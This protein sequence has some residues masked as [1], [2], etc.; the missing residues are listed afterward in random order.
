M[1]QVQ[2][3]PFKAPKT[4]VAIA[5]KKARELVEGYDDDNIE[6][7]NTDGEVIGNGDYEIKEGDRVLIRATQEGWEAAGYIIFSI[8]VGVASYYFASQLLGNI[9]DKP[10]ESYSLTGVSNAFNKYSPVPSVLGRHRVTPPLAAQPWIFQEGEDEYIRALYLFGYSPMSLSDFKIGD[11]SLDSFVDENGDPNYELEIYDGLD[12]RTPLTLY[13]NDVFQEN[14][15]VET[16][17]IKT[18]TSSATGIT[19][20][21]VYVTRTVA[22]SGSEV[23]ATIDFPQGLYGVKND[24]EYVHEEAYHQITFR[25]DGA[26]GAGYLDGGTYTLL[27]MEYVPNESDLNTKGDINTVG[28]KVP[29]K[30]GTDYFTSNKP[31]NGLVVKESGSFD[32]DLYVCRQTS[33][34]TFRWNPLTKVYKEFAANGITLRRTLVTPEVIAGGMFDDETWYDDPVINTYTLGPS[35]II[36]NSFKQGGN[37]GSEPFRATFGLKKLTKSVYSVGVRRNEP[38]DSRRE[39]RRFDK[40]VYLFLTSIDNETPPV[41]LGGISLVAISI[42]ASEQ[43]NGQIEGFSAIAQAYTPPWNYANWG[44]NLS[45]SYSQ[46]GGESDSDAYLKSIDSD[47]ST[48]DSWLEGIRTFVMNNPAGVDDIDN[49]SSITVDSDPSEFM[50]P[51]ANPA[52]MYRWA[53]QGRSAKIRAPDSKLDF[54]LSEGSGSLEE[55]R[56]YCNTPNVVG[57]DVGA[58]PSAKRNFECNAVV[59]Y[60]TTVY[61]LLS[62]ICSTANGRFI[63]NNGKYGVSLDKAKDFS[64]QLFTDDNAEITSKKEFLDQIDG[65]QVRFKDETDDNYEQNEFPVINPLKKTDLGND[66]ENI[67]LWGV[68]NPAQA[69][70]LARTKFKSR[71]VRSQTFDITTDIDGIVCQTGDR[72][73]IQNQK[74]LR[75]ITGA[76]IAEVSGDVITLDEPVVFDPG[77]NYGIVVRNADGTVHTAVSITNPGVTTAQ[78]T[79]VGHSGVVGDLVSVGQSGIE[80][81]ELMV[82]DIEYDNDLRARLTAIPYVESL[83]DNDNVIDET[84]PGINIPYPDNVRHDA[85]VITGVSLIDQRARD[86]RG[87][88][89][90]SIRLSIVSPFIKNALNPQ[91]EVYY[92]Y[93]KD[94]TTQKIPEIYAGRVPTSAGSFLLQNLELGEYTFRVR[95]VSNTGESDF[96]SYTYTLS[97]DPARV[98]DVGTVTGIELINR[99]NNAGDIEDD[100]VVH[101]FFGEDAKFRWRLNALNNSE[102]IGSETF[103][104]DSGAQD[105][106]FEDYQVVIAEKKTVNIN[107]PTPQTITTYIPRREEIVA[108]PAYTYTYEDNLEDG[109]GVAT[110]SF[111]IAV[112]ARGSENQESQ[113]AFLDVKNPAPEIPQNFTASVNFTE[114]SFG[115]TKPTDADI[116]AFE[117]YVSTISGFDPELQDPTYSGPYQ[118]PVTL[119]NLEADRT[120]Y[121]RAR[122]VDTFGEGEFTDQISFATQQPSGVDITP[123]TAPDNL[124]VTIGTQGKNYLQ[125]SFAELSW[126]AAFDDSGELF[127][128]VEHGLVS[129]TKPT[130]ATT[131]DTTYIIPYIDVDNDYKF[132]VRA[133]DYSGNTSAWTGYSTVSA[134][135]VYD[136]PPGA[137]ITLVG[138]GTEFSGRDAEFIIEQPEI[139]DQENFKGYVVTVKDGATVLRT[140]EVSNPFYS[141]TYEKNVNDGGPRRTF[142]VE[143][144]STTTDGQ[145]GATSSITV[146]NPAPVASNVTIEPRVGALV[147]RYDEPTDTDFKGTR[148]YLSETSPVTINDTNLKYNGPEY[149]PSFITG[150]NLN[151][152]YYVTVVPYD[153]FG[154]GTPTANLS[155]VTL[156]NEDITPPVA[157]SNLVLSQELT[158]DNLSATV[159]LEASWD[160]GSD[161]SGNF[162]YYVTFTSANDVRTLVTEDTSTSLMPAIIG[163][164]YTVTV[165]SLDYSGNESTSSISDTIAIVGSSTSPGATTNE[166]VTG[167]LNKVKLTWDNPTT[168]NF[169]QTKVYRGTTAGFTANAGSLIAE[170]RNTVYVDIDV[171]NGTDY[172][173]KL[174]PVSA[175]GTNGT[176][177]AAVGPA[178][179]FTMSP[180]NIDDYMDDETIEAVKFADG[181]EP[182][183]IVASL[184]NPVGYTGPKTVLLTSDSKLYRYDAS[185]PEWTK[186]VDTTEL[187]GEI[188]ETQIANDAITTPKILAGNIVTS[189]MTAGGIDA[190]RLV[191]NSIEAGQ[192]STGAL[193]AAVIRGDIIQ[194]AASGARVQLD[195]FNGIRVYN[196]SSQQTAHIS[197]DGSG[198]LGRNGTYPVISWDTAGQVQIPGELLVSEIDADLITTGTLD[199]GV[200]NVTNLNADNINSGTITSIDI[201]GTNITGTST[202][203]GAIIRTSATN[204]KVQMDSGNGLFVTSAAGNVTF[205]ADINGAISIGSVNPI[206]IDTAG[207]VTVTAAVSVTGSISGNTIRSRAGADSSGVYYV[208]LT[209][210]TTPF[211]L[212]DGT[213]TLIEMTQV[214]NMIT[215]GNIYS[216]GKES[217]YDPTNGYWIGSSGTVSIGKKTGSAAGTGS[218][219]VW[220]GT[221]LYIGGDSYFEGTLTATTVDTSGISVGTIKIDSTNGIYSTTNNFQLTPAGDLTI[222]GDITAS[223]ITGSTLTGGTIQTSSGLGERLVITSSQSIWYDSSNN[224]ILSIGFGGNKLGLGDTAVLEINTNTSSYRNGV[225]VLSANI[226]PAIQA[227]N[228]NG[229]STAVSGLSNGGGIGVF[230]RTSSGDGTGVAGIMGSNL[231]TGYA[232]Y[233]DTSSGTGVF[234]ASGSGIGARGQSSTNIGVYGK[235]TSNVGVYGESSSSYGVYGNSSSS[236]A[237]YG[238]TGV[239]GGAAVFADSTSSASSAVACLNSGSGVPIRFFTSSLPSASSFSNSFTTTGNNV[240]W[241]NGS[242]WTK[243]NGSVS[244]LDYQTGSFD[245]SGGNPD[246]GTVSLSF[247]NGCF[248]VWLSAAGTGQGTMAVTA[249]SNT[250]FSYNVDGGRSPVTWI[251]FGY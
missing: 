126:D 95:T 223:D 4:I 236:H 120:F 244:S 13:P 102:E 61:E 214:G 39:G 169:L 160:A 73:S 196:A 148:L 217:L 85:P 191:A 111:R 238:E 176:L 88:V 248:G 125:T 133:V 161:D 64:V 115:A 199:A 20:R 92:S 113:Q 116:T 40:S 22:Q 65:Y 31:L 82:V 110:R 121:V 35:T 172:Y 84:P 122:Y 131:K 17:L 53:L 208:Q 91:F 123:P 41:K 109:N 225:S 98:P 138:G 175:S 52:Y 56:Q 54:N 211:R 57:Y 228:T 151:Q 75:G 137:G 207:N 77:E 222:S 224:T 167:F 220:D 58:A 99:Q 18:E 174:Q 141:Y 71:Y 179:P 143:V 213:T 227:I 251:A 234:G 67:E 134:G 152:Q 94:G 140:E 187:D 129:A 28:N 209:D 96:T 3:N 170:T 127:Y 200:V 21:G 43:L 59:D 188:T 237:V 7:V 6:V 221:S 229:S 124:V 165:K 215:S 219:M 155:V 145:T 107:F 184:P 36:K 15:S 19:P 108:Q 34:G 193:S 230:G 197:N 232:V 55:F 32:P 163:D 51:A 103:G 135:T 29:S 50:V 97:Y 76:R 105:V 159:K 162:Y 250:Q 80:T 46:S 48:Y 168:S 158:E 247:P 60:K 74:L 30:I 100:E 119:V 233:G 146:T 38:Y 216:T 27:D 47:N 83:Y 66:Y 144:Y 114:V 45:L 44:D 72:I 173:Y 86:D 235:S 149:N 70:Y 195:K 117:I 112:K 218:G 106:Y 68:T 203:T 185:V 241:S 153:V 243:M 118:S 23:S 101:Y 136:A 24:G 240:Y 231:S 183:S 49:P 249:Y 246:T 93:V 37:G 147:V 202:I 62:D 154:A 8:V 190:D 178:T 157:P 69:Q 142:T 11:T 194:T 2:N 177:S 180:L 189:H 226:Y 206:T 87:K 182:V 42:K 139:P 201:T 130:V 132:R 78:F 239:S 171:S 192:I 212:W 16:P 164:T 5:G 12:N 1:L 10:G 128:E 181:I 242:S 14:I 166:T 89:Y 90:S 245:T 156:T 150:L 9:G 26:P 198:F 204:P 63:F 186:K 81:T 33:P 79:A 205:N 25:H 210:G 104:A